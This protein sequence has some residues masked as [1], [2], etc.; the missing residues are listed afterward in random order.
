MGEFQSR[1]IAATKNLRLRLPRLPLEPALS[2]A[3]LNGVGPDRWIC[4]QRLGGTS[5]TS[6]APVGDSF[7]MG[8]RDARPSEDGERGRAELP[9]SPVNGATRQ[10]RPTT[11]RFIAGEQV[12]KPTELPR[13]PALGLIEAQQGCCPAPDAFLEAQG[14]CRRRRGR[15][16]AR[17]P[18]R[19]RSR[20][21]AARRAVPSGERAGDGVGGAGAG[22]VGGA[23][24]GDSRRWRTRAPRQRQGAGAS[25]CRTTPLPN[26]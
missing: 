2:G 1:I 6:P 15:S 23:D 9:L 22:R 10:R 12:E 26:P 5:S 21:W 3:R 11:Q 20:S 17:P 18:G 4:R 24:P 8:T 19:T 16:W 13:Q 25:S 14:R 7:Q